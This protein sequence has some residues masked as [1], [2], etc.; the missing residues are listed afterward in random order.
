MSNTIDS[1][2]SD[3][4]NL[5]HI[6]NSMSVH[7]I[8]TKNKMTADQYSIF[9]R[10]L[11]KE[12][13]Q[14]MPPALQVFHS[15]KSS[16]VWI[17]TGVVRTGSWPAKLIAKVF[18]FPSAGDNIPITVTVDHELN[19][20]EEWQERWTRTFANASF[21]SVL[22]LTN[23]NQL[24][25]SFPPFTFNLGVHADEKQLNMPVV[26]WRIG[27]LTLPN[28]L[29]PVSD[30]KEFQDEQGRFRFDVK[31]SHPIIGLI[32][33]YQGWLEEKEI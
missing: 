6:E 28:F 7:G 30:A 33:H 16:S 15:T 12:T 20:L 19:D 10:S 24:T 2:D 32:A 4:L 3:M 25:E 14:K 21:S 31:L 17:G 29:A 22:K 5:Q 13:F 23:D 11:G 8:T 1:L 27:F 18:G 9:E 26:G